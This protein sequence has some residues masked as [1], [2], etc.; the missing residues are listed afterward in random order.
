MGFAV[1][2]TEPAGVCPALETP[3][4]AELDPEPRSLTPQS[5]SL[6]LFDGAFQR[7]GS[8]QIDLLAIF[9]FKKREIVSF[10][11]KLQSLY[12][13]NIYLSFGEKFSHVQ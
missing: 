7:L 2:H 9:P 1:S 10:P 3:V 5:V 11:S 13:I 8:P 6:L 4:S 12:H